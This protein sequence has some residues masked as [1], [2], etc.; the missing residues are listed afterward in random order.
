MLALVLKSRKRKLIMIFDYIEF[1][2]MTF[3]IFTFVI[4]NAHP[5]CFLNL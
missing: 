5:S 1:K 2:E 3:E 4:N